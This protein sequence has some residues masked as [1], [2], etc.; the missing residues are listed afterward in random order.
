VLSGYFA[1]R[2]RSSRPFTVTD[3]RL[4]G[5]VWFSNRYS[6]A[7]PYGLVFYAWGARRELP[8]GELKNYTA[9]KDRML[10]RPAVRRALDDQQI[11]V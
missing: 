4:A 10:Q 11:K 5:R 9:F 3:A 1:A 8:V 6:A 7:D 2:T